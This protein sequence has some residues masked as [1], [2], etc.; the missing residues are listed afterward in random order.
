MTTHVQTVYGLRRVYDTARHIPLCGNPN[1]CECRFM[2]DAEFQSHTNP[3]NAAGGAP[4][5]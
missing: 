4:A 3:E 5:P 2:A 1:L